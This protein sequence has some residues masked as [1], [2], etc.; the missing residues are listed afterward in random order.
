[1]PF[2]NVSNNDTNIQNAKNYINKNTNT[3]RMTSAFE[4]YESYSTTYENN[5]KGNLIFTKAA[6]NLAQTNI[7]SANKYIDN[8]EILDEYEYAEFF[9][10][11][12]NALLEQYWEMKDLTEIKDESFNKENTSSNCEDGNSHLSFLDLLS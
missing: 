9:T 5:F 4:I 10:S 6:E 1:M 12:N 2:L 3:K 11:D 8:N 7:N